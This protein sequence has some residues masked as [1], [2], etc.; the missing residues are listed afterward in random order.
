LSRRRGTNQWLVF[1]AVFLA[2][3]AVGGVMLYLYTSEMPMSMITADAGITGEELEN[4]PLEMAGV[5]PYMPYTPPNRYLHVNLMIISRTIR[6]EIKSPDYPV[7][8]PV[9]ATIYV[10]GTPSGSVTCW[11]SRA[12]YTYFTGV[13]TCR[14]LDNIYQP[15]IPYDKWAMLGPYVA[16]DQELPNG[17][18]IYEVY[19][20]VK[21]YRVVFTPLETVEWGQLGPKRYSSHLEPYK[22]FN[23]IKVLETTIIK[24]D[25]GWYVERLDI[26]SSWWTPTVSGT[27][28]LSSIP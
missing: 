2:V 17:R 5:G 9:I 20:S 13:W 27:Y 12:N 15:R 21:I 28:K 19:L 24:T 1:T 3:V 6:K 26:Y 18:L 4:F 11:T 14:F 25:Q 8:T 10:N 16:R 22:E 7:I 23:N